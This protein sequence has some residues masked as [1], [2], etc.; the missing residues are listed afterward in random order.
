MARRY[1]RFDQP[2]RH[3][4]PSAPPPPA[5][6]ATSSRLTSTRYSRPSTAPAPP[7]TGTTAPQLTSFSQAS[8]AT[9]RPHTRPGVA[10]APDA[11]AFAFAD[12]SRRTY[13]AYAAAKERVSGVRFANGLHPRQ[14]HGGLSSG[15]Q[16]AVAKEGGGSVGQARC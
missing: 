14:D 16:P 9:S 13:S 10:V 7:P 3:H 1:H 11:E 15:Q 4:F 5:M 2:S 6:S 12:V 8:R